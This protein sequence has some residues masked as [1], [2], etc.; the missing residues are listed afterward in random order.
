MRKL[1]AVALLTGCG[2]ASAAP[3]P[4]DPAPP[5]QDALTLHTIEAA[6]PVEVLKP[7]VRLAAFQETPVPDQR[8]DLHAPTGLFGLPLA[9]LGLD[10]CA[11]MNFYRVQMGLPE[12][13]SDQPRT[14]PKRWW[15]LGWRESNCRNDV[16]TFCCYG[17]WQIA[18]ANR[19]AHGY[20]TAG[21]FTNC[22]VRYLSDWFGSAPEQKQKS[23]CIAANMYRYH[24]ERGEDARWMAWDRWL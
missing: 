3:L 6:H 8:D 13:W 17:Y 15:G 5:L 23:A 2:A 22:G 9:P 21:V 16:K 4:S 24:T 20:K 10:A 14:G 12:G 19:N 11:E 1:L 18:W 7:A